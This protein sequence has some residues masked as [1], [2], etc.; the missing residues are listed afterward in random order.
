[1]K[2]LKESYKDN[3]YYDPKE[4]KVIINYPQ[5]KRIELD[6]DERIYSPYTE[7]EYEYEVDIDDVFY[8]IQDFLYDAS[9]G[10]YGKELEDKYYPLY[11][12]LEENGNTMENNEF[13]KW[14]ISIIDNLLAEEIICKLIYNKYKEDAD[15]DY[16]WENR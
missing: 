4:E 1:M 15:D 7:V 2:L 13:W 11:M 8:V 10:D 6:D 12:Q 9:N 14:F 3:V 5:L 16:S